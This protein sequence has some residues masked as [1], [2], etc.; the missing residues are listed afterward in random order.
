MTG[1]T[2]MGVRSRIQYVLVHE[3]VTG[4]GLAGEPLH[5]SWAAEGRAMRRAL[6]ADFAA[7]PGVRVVMTLDARLPDEPGPWTTVRVGPGQERATLARLASEAEYTTLIAPETGGILA[8]RARWIAVVGGRSLGSSPEAIELTGD[9]LRLAEHL[10]SHGIATPAV[11]VVVPAD[12][13]PEA[14]DYPAVLKPIDG[15]GS[16][17]TF[18][19]ASATDVPVQARTQS[20]ALLQ[21]FVVGDPMSASFLVASD[22]GVF[23]IGVGRQH[24]E[25]RDGRFVYR[26][27]SVPAVVSASL[28]PVR[29]A[30]A[31]VP[32]LRG[33]VGADFIGN[34]SQGLVTVLEINPRLTTSYVGLRQ[35]LPR[36]RLAEAWLAAMEGA[37]GGLRSLAWQV[38]VARTVEFLAGAGRE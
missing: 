6:A 34:A 12:G 26:G 11:R 33:F 3:Y 1:I 30:V 2:R 15:A 13:L 18:F 27:G 28:D 23:L 10:A 35:L 9:K 31:S 7:V 22:G 32:G 14:F 29:R 21:P 20:R 24:I 17:D 38:Q 4:G 37:E 36:G 5:P 25:R 8:D 19:V 16:V